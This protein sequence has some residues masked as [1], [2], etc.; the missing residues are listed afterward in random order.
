M[1]NVAKVD[2]RTSLLGYESSLPIYV[3]AT[4]LGRLGHPEGEV[5][6]T[7]AAAQTGLIQ[8]IPTLASCSLEE[9]TSARSPGQ[10]QFFQ[11]YVN[12]NRDITRSL[13]QKA[14]RLGCRALFITVD[15]PTLAKREKD[16]RT[17][18]TL[19]P[20]RVQEGHDVNRNAGAARAIGSFIDSG[21]SWKD[22]PWFR[23]ITSLPIV[24]KGVQCGEDAVLA[25]QHGVNGIVVSNHG[26]RQL[27]FARSAIEV[28]PEV[29]D[30]LRGI[31]ADL[32]KFEVYIDGG[33]RRGTDIFKAL[34]LG[35]RAVGIGRPFLFAMSTYGEDGVKHAIQ[36]LRDEFEMVMRLMGTPTLRDIK[37]QMLCTKNLATHVTAVPQDHLSDDIYDHLQPP[38]LQS[39]I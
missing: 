37:P 9:I 28:L 6:L 24:L 38:R 19:A 15:A 12:G 35:A 26:G 7:R 34:A 22:L 23:S 2:T 10:T 25:Y 3:T 1:V 17:K 8:M 16:M 5:V 33:I 4:A 30:A 18:F 13:V 20:P 29:M 31:N 36:I 21:L 32:T 39:K 14:E 27:D 11:L